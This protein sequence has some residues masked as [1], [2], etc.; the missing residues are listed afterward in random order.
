M[1][2]VIFCKGHQAKKPYLIQ[3]LKL[4]I[5]SLEELCYYIY[6][7]VSLCD[8]ELLKPELAAWLEYQCGLPDLAESLRVVLQK[9]PAAERVAAQIF[10]YA[11]YLGRQERE[12]I[13]ET[14]RKYSLLGVYE[15][16]KMRGDYFYLD[17]KYQEAIKDYEE[18][19]VKEAYDDE[20]MKH[21]LLYNIGCC[22]G[23]MFYYDI[24]YGWFLQAAAMDIS[25]GEDI[26]AALFCRRMSLDDH[27]WEEYLA[28][29]EELATFAP[30]M[31]K[32]MKLLE[33]AWEKEPDAQKFTAFRKGPEGR[34]TDYYAYMTKCLDEW[35][36]RI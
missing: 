8:Q 3:D 14:I 11:D 24:A 32:Q 26:M 22:Y 35:K 13:C 9:T 12:A 19:L 36:C 7:N 16:R 4:H 6:S 25:K 30:P 17:G 29:H 5:Y 28:A 20:K 2:Y 23:A 21:H 31:E 18:M 1:S 10:T 27:A 33:E 15:R 34:K